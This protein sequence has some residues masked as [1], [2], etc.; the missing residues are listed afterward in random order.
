MDQYC[1]ALVISLLQAWTIYWTSSRTASDLRCH[2]A[3]WRHCNYQIIQ[4]CGASRKSYTRF[5][6]LFL[7]CFNLVPAVFID[8]LS[9]NS[10]IYIYIKTQT[11][12]I[13]IHIYPLYNNQP[14]PRPDSH[15]V[16]GQYNLYFLHEKL[17]WTV[18]EKT[19]NIGSIGQFWNEA[20][21][22]Q[23]TRPADRPFANV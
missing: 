4:K 2:D 19:S 17:Y 7:F 16:I 21:R 8:S 18:L 9:V 22:I 13:Y 12:Y 5:A 14:I 20:A 6:F 23:P 15:H 1:K 10:F 11:L 3:Q